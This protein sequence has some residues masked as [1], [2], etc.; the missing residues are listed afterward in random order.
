MDSALNMVRQEPPRASTS[1][2]AIILKPDPSRAIQSLFLSTA[3]LLK[4]TDLDTVM[5]NINFAA[6]HL[7]LLRGVQILP[8]HISLTFL[9]LIYRA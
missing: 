3:H 1:S 4:R 9:I 7:A 8:F 5:L 6:I 2:Q